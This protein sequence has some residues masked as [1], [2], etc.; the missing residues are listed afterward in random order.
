[1]FV[2]VYVCVYCWSCLCV[3]LCRFVYLCVCVRVNV[4]ACVCV[5]VCVLV[6]VFVCAPV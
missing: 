1:V 6:D 5:C 4:C 2:P 3:R